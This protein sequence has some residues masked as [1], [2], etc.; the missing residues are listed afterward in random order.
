MKTYKHTENGLVIRENG[1]FV[2]FSWDDPQISALFNFTNIGDVWTEEDIP[3]ILEDVPTKP[4]IDRVHECCGKCHAEEGTKYSV[5]FKTVAYYDVEIFAESFK[6]ALEKANNIPA[7]DIVTEGE[8]VDIET[9]VTVE[10][11]LKQS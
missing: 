5:Q 2:S 8:L 9:P 1:K 4:P 11:I 7:Y 6:E 10:G 3:K